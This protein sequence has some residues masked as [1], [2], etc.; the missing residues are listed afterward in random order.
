MPGRAAV[1]L[2]PCAACTSRPR[3]PGARRGSRGSRRRARRRERL[4]HLEHQLRRVG[5]QD[6]A[7][8]GDAAA[9]DHPVGRPRV[10]RLVVAVRPTPTPARRGPRSAVDL[11]PRARAPA[12]A[13]RSR[14]G[15]S[16]QP[17][18]RI[19]A[20]TQL[21]RERSG[22]SSGSPE[23]PTGGGTSALGD[24]RA[25]AVRRLQRRDSGLVAALQD[26]AVRAPGR[27]RLRFC[28]RSSPISASAS[29]PPRRRIRAVAALQYQ[30]PVPPVARE[31]SMAAN[32]PGLWPGTPTTV[33]PVRD[34]VDDH[35]IG[36]DL[37]PGADREPA[38]DLRAGADMRVGPDGRG[39]DD[40]PWRS[41][42]VTNGAIVTPA[43]DLGDP[44]DHHLAVHQVEARCDHHRIADRHLA[45]DHREP[46]GDAAAAAAPR[47]P[48]SAPSRG[49]APGRGR[50]RS[51]RPAAAPASTASARERNS[52]RSPRYG[53]VTRASAH[54]GLTKAGMARANLAHQRL[55]APGADPPGIGAGPTRTSIDCAPLDSARP[56]PAS[57]FPTDPDENAASLVNL[58]EVLFAL[59]RCGRGDAR[60]SRSAP[61]TASR[62]SELL[63]WA[64]RRRRAH[65]RDRPRAPSRRCAS[66]LPSA[67]ELELIERTSHR[68]PRRASTPTRSSSTATTTTSRSAR[69][70][71]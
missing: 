68:G 11:R 44:V 6:V 32:L 31:E 61:S 4:E 13:R 51:A 38:E 41:P 10:E 16:A 39:P 40:S 7:G 57:L 25:A 65:A 46:V 49:R 22:V 27:A 35:R 37:R 33:A 70:C 23:S 67:P 59:P 69:S 30:C 12:S 34:V 15:R 2:D 14:R 21:R 29:G 50:R 3:S 1:G 64:E 18:A 54:R 60:W 19:A 58:G 66:W 56:M 17:R 63:G 20:R 45:D 71:G 42:I 28:A 9:L 8:V 43:G 36:P 26:R 48:A 47:A 52:W 24:Q 5:G 62:P 55:R 53:A